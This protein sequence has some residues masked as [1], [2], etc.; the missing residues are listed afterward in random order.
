VPPTT[1]QAFF[2]A[3]V[4]FGEINYTAK[5]MKL[6]DGMTYGFQ[7]LVSPEPGTWVLSAG[8]ILIVLMLRRRK[9]AVNS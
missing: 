8:G 2:D 7:N 5:D 4:M 6:Y 3:T 9:A 1:A